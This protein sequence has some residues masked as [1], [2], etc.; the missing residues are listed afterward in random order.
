[1]A[2]TLRRR[3]LTGYG[4]AMVLTGLVLAWGLV[5]LT[6][7]GQASDAILR[8][9]YRSILA[10]ERMRDAI[11]RQENATVLLLVSDKTHQ[12]PEAVGRLTGTE[13]QFL[14]NLAKAKDN[15]TI[16]GEGEILAKI[17]S[18]YNAYMLSVT[19]LLKSHR[20]DPDAGLRFY[21]QTMKPHVVAVRDACD[22]LLELNQATMEAGSD[23]ARKV[24]H[25]AIWSMLL[26]GL[27][28]IVVGAVFSWLLSARITR[29]VRLLAEAARQVASGDYQTRVTCRSHDEFEGLAERFNVMVAKLR[30]FNDLKVGQIIA[31]KKKNET[32]LQTIDDGVLVVDA[33]RRITS[34][35]RAAARA[36][37][38]DPAACE[39]A[40]FRELVRDENLARCVEEALSSGEAPRAAAD[41]HYLTVAAG[42]TEVHYD[43]T[44]TPVQAAA[45]KLIGVVVL[46]R[47]VT[48]LRELDRLKSEFVMTASHELRTPLTSI[49][50]SIGL[51]R[52]RMADKVSPSDRELLNAAHEETVRLTQLVNELLDLTRIEAGK[53]E[54]EYAEVSPATLLLG[55][56]APFRSQ[57]QEKSVELALDVPEGLPAVRVDANKMT[58][59][60]T[61]LLGNAIRYT[62]PGGHIWVSAEPAGPWL[63]LYVRDDGAGIPHEKQAMIFGKFVQVAGPGQAGGAGLGLAISKEIVRAHRGSIWVESEPGR[64]SLFTIALP[65]TNPS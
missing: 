63:H 61:N 47:D 23:R 56:V 36:L 64:G 42:A 13:Q 15:V 17:E 16:P 27:A 3:I 9:N 12:T 52:E 46:L 26:V 59:V 48:R 62:E 58:W 6:W 41:D 60:V 43:Y 24:A 19:E 33:N 7:L 49:T 38:I 44:I 54:M 2:Y 34:L 20:S 25:A 11:Q 1:M 37:G 21:E 65:I 10:A 28:A 30:A 51:L 22:R 18:E 39:K 14:L 29:P 4:I 57:A 40:E 35:N 45:G 32:I 53:I 8:E 31:E 5:N 50:M 55:A